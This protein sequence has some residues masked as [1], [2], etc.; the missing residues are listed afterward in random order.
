[1]EDLFDKENKSQNDNH[2][3]EIIL[4]RVIEYINHKKISN[5]RIY[6]DFNLNHWNINAWLKM[7]NAIRLALKPLG[8]YLSIQKI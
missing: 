3:K 1:M 6:T 5:D 2:T 8:K 7:E 4:R